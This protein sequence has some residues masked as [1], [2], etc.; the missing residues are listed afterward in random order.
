[1][2]KYNIPALFTPLK[3]ESKRSYQNNPNSEDKI[4]G[5]NEPKMLEVHTHQTIAIGYVGPVQGKEVV[6]NQ[7]HL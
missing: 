6:D 7:C 3:H 4:N 5:G 1:M 2:A